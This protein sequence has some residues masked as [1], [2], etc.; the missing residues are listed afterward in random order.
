MMTYDREALSDSLKGRITCGSTKGY[1]FFQDISIEETVRIIG[2][3]HDEITKKGLEAIP[4][5]ISEGRLVGRAETSKYF[6]TVYHIEFSWSP[7]LIPIERDHF[8]QILVEY[9]QRIGDAMS[10]ERIYLEFEGKTEVFKKRQTPLE[11]RA[12]I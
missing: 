10:Q 9:A 1:R 2:K 5:I 12:G 3:I 6:E 8:Y 7:R 4:C 11:V